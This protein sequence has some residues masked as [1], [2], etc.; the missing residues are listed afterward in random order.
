MASSTRKTRC[1]Q[2]RGTTAGYYCQR[3]RFMFLLVV[4]TKSSEVRVVKGA[5]WKDKT[6]IDR[7]LKLPGDRLGWTAD[8]LGGYWMDRL[9]RRRHQ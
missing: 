7:T 6:C 5:V 4:R 3:L 8:E 2:S 9:A 1:P